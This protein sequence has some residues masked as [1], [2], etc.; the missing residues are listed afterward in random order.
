MEL[1]I[2]CLVYDC[3]TSL[4]Q[5]TCIAA[6]VLRRTILINKLIFSCVSKE[7]FGMEIQ[8][9]SS[10]SATVLACPFSSHGYCTYWQDRIF[11]IFGGS[12]FGLY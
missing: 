7:K 2:I 3:F 5:Y 11:P 4:L 1:I 9:M 8:I 10:M 6:K 12:V